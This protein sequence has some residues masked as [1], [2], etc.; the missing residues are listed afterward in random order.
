MALTWTEKIIQQKYEEVE[1]LGLD[2]G[3]YWNPQHSGNTGYE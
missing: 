1:T 3:I 2:R